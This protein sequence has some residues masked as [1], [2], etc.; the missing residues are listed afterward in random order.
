MFPEQSGGIHDDNSPN[1]ADRVMIP[2][3]IVDVFGLV[4]TLVFTTSSLVRYCLHSHEQGA[5]YLSVPPLLHPP[6]LSGIQLRGF[7]SGRKAALKNF[8]DTAAAQEVTRCTQ[9]LVW[10]PAFSLPTPCFSRA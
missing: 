9:L 4:I 10:S 5:P 8:A 6:A 1:Y 3:S 7:F 2:K